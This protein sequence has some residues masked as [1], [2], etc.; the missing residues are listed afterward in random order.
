M[1]EIYGGLVE[2]SGGTFIYNEIIANPVNNDTQLPT[3]TPVSLPDD[4]PIY[5]APEV[6]E[7]PEPE[8]E[9]TVA[10][11]NVFEEPVILTEEQVTFI[12]DKAEYLHPEEAMKTLQ[13]I[14]DY[15]INHPSITILLAGTTAGDTDSDFSLSL[16]L[17]RGKAVMN[18]LVDLGVDADRIIAVGLG[19]AKDPWH[20]WGAGY[21]GAAAS[22]NRK[23]VLLDADS[24]TALEILERQ[25]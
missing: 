12:G 3:V 1:Q 13:P 6:F 14:A 25:K 11:E 17:S 21:D 7:M 23:V 18:S 22:S 9:E 4:T 2:E 15:L 20:I 8:D 16:S 5:F 10:E 24:D 19:S